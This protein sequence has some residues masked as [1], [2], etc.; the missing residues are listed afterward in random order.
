MPSKTDRPATTAS[1]GAQVDDVVG[2]G[3]YLWLVLHDEHRVPLV[4]QPEEQLVHT[5][6][7]WGCSPIDGSS[8]TYVTSVRADSRW[9]IILTRWASPPERVP[10]GR[11]RDR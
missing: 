11:S 8:N 4:P 2:N 10:E 1:A 5:A 6:M 3:D 9:R 7:S